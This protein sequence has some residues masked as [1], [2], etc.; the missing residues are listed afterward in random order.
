MHCGKNCLKTLKLKHNN[1][2]FKNTE[3]AFLST[4]SVYI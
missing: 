2:H 4:Y 1:L 3:N